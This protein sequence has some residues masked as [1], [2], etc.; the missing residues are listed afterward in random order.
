MVQSP[1]AKVQSPRS[2]VQGAEIPDL[3]FEISA[4]LNWL[5]NHSNADGGWGDTINSLSNIST[6][7]LCWAAFG[8]VPGADEQ[9]ESV[10]NPAEKWLASRLADH[11]SRPPSAVPL[12]RTGI[13]DHASLVN[14]IIARYGNDRTFSAPILTDCALA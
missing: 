9:Y 1:K 10:V 2:E 5:A 14:A 6:T 4:G 13:T 8:A 7:A 12:R 3:E 11:A